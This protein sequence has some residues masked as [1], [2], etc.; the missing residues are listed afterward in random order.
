MGKIEGKPKGVKEK[1]RVGGKKKGD[2]YSRAIDNFVAFN[3]R[4]G[5]HH[6]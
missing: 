4:L 3:L 5:C 2:R 6:L 1:E